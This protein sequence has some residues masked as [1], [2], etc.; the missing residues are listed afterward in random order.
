[1]V[2]VTTLLPS[3]RF[4]TDSDWVWF[5]IVLIG[6]SRK[7]ISLSVAPNWTILTLKQKIVEVWN[8]QID[9]IRLI[10]QGKQLN[11][12]CTIESYGIETG[13]VIHRVIRCKG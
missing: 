11:D 1:M 4:L 12:E 6:A 8:I 3:G 9:E 10:Y 7:V 5:D 2:D 13:S